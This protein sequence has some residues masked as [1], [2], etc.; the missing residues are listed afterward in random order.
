MP[1]GL[2]FGANTSDRVDCGSGASLDDLTTGT[3]LV[4]EHPT[5]LTTGRDIVSKY[6]GATGEGWRFSNGTG[7]AGLLEF[8]IERATTTTFYVASSLTRSTGSWYCS[9]ATWDH[10]ATPVVHL[11]T[12]LYDAAT[13]EPTYSIAR[14][15]SG[16]FSSDAARSLFIGNRDVASPVTSYQGTIAIVAVYNRVLSAAEIDQWRSPRPAPNTPSS[17]LVLFTLLG[18]GG[19]TGQQ[20][21][22]SGNGN[23]GTVVGCTASSTQLP[24]PKWSMPAIMHYYRM[25]GA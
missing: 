8:E 17:G 23:H 21:D 1:Y 15:G 16:A 6:R 4:M 20:D 22:Q 19:S 3:V 11:Y 9:A 13:A 7:T 5:T 2:T 10:A 24:L 12:G 14:D 25:M 18:D